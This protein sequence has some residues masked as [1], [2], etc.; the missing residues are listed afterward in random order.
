MALDADKIA[1]KGIHC[2]IGSQIFEKQSFVLAVEKCMNFVAKMKQNLGF[3]LETLNIGGGFGIWYTDEDRKI[4]E[5]ANERILSLRKRYGNV[6]FLFVRNRSY[7][8]KQRKSFRLHGEYSSGI[9]S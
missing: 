5:N 7:S 1:F 8:K 3:T 4:L 6:F 2:H 9:W